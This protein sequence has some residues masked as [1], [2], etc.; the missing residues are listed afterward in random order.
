MNWLG[1]DWPTI[2]ENLLLLG[3]AYLLALPIAYNREKASRSA[4][5]RTYPMVALGTCGLMLVGI[6][7]MGTTD[8][9][10]RVMQAIITGMGFI[11]GGAI[12]KG[13]GR[14]T[15]LATASSLWI[16]GAIGIAVAWQRYEVAILLSL[17]TFLTLA[18]VP[19]AKQLVDKDPEED[20]PD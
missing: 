7:V 8:A 6:K 1:V 3:A 19:S 4:G 16:T 11:G 5:L 15:G 13:D 20:E 2:L 9:E 14:V 17:V 18:I 10:A 12:L